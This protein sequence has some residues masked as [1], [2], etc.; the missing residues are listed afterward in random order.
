MNPTE[1]EALARN[2]IDSHL[3]ASVF[4]SHVSWRFVWNNR[5]RA[6]GVCR[7]LPR[8]IQ[9][10]RPWVRVNEEADVR[11]TILHEIAHALA[12]PGNGHNARWKAIAVRLGDSNASRLCGEHTVNPPSP[13]VG[14]CA[15][16]HTAQAYRKPSERRQR[17]SCGKCSRGWNPAHV[18][19]WRKV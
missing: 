1:A 2:L 9:L 16:G 8:E 5:K 14:T 12:G 6:A 7:F 13:W 15:A 18:F 4:L 11:S 19:V 3:N 10:S 17:S